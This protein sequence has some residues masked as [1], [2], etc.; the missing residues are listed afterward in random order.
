MENEEIILNEDIEPTPEPEPFVIP[1]IYNYK[2]DTKEFTGVVEQADK[3]NAKSAQVGY[4]VPLVHANATL[5]EPPTVEENQIQVYSKTVE[6]HKEP[7][8]VIDP[9]TGEKHIEYRT[10]EEVIEN[11]EI[12][13]DYR[14]NFYKVDN[15]LNVT[16]IITIG[17][18]EGYIIVDKAT[19]EDVKA[20]KDWYKIVDNEVVKKSDEE[21]ELQELQKAKVL[22]IAENDRLRDEALNA[23]VEYKGILFDSDTDQKVNLLATVSMMNTISLGEGSSSVNDSELEMQG[24]DSIITWFGKN[25]EPLE[26]T[27]G[28]LT[29]IGALITELH[30][31]CWTRNAEIKASISLAED[32]DELDDITIDYTLGD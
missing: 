4:F 5:L 2:P 30:T 23:G 8:E 6:T 18:Q 27:V 9:E 10:V 17:E 20:N 21:I 29:A 25:N 28:D 15:D 24:D 16:D 14:K 11:W 22:K 7:Y 12:Q 3:D 1:N 26:C 19:G 32:I 13:L 31:F